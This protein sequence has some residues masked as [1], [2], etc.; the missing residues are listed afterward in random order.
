MTVADLRRLLL[1]FKTMLHR[2]LGQNVDYRT[3]I[4]SYLDKKMSGFSLEM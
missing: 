4:A 1:P 2:S 3:M